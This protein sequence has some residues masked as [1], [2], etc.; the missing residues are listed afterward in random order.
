MNPYTA[1]ML[2]VIIW[3]VV[4]FAVLPWGA[5]PPENPEPGHAPSAPA[6][7]M[8]IRKAVITTVIS[9]VIWGVLFYLITNDILVF[10]EF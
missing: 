10:R 3:W 7:P 4:I 2:F 1:I 5:R 8:L 9:A 6:K